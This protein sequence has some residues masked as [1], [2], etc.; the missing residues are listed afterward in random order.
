MEQE[1]PWRSRTRA[2]KDE[3]MGSSEVMQPTRLS[4]VCTKLGHHKRRTLGT[5]TLMGAANAFALALEKQPQ[6]RK[7]VIDN[8][9]SDTGYWSEDLGLFDTASVHIWCPTCRQDMRFSASDFSK[10]ARETPRGN[11]SR[12][13]VSVLWA[14]LMKHRHAD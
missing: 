12:V 9:G 7:G 2:E 10:L 14:I 11:E 8:R 1:R 3:I 13:D 4:V 6:E 5:L